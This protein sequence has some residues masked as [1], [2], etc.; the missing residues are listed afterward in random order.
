MPF[1]SKEEIIG[2][3]SKDGNFVTFPVP[4]VK[5]ITAPTK[6]KVHKRIFHSFLKFTSYFL[7]FYIFNM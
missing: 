6:W 1:N 4:D 3:V 5:T 2:A 7:S